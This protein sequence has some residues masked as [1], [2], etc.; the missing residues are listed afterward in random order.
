MISFQSINRDG[1]GVVETEGVPLFC[2]AK[3]RRD[4]LDQGRTRSKEDN[5]PGND[6]CDLCSRIC[7]G[8]LVHSLQTTIENYKSWPEYLHGAERNFRGVTYNCHRSAACCDGIGRCSRSCGCK[9]RRPSR[10]TSLSIVRSWIRIEPPGDALF[11]S[12]AGQQSL[13]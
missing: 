11:Q 1:Y 4:L 6:N 5:S 13:S 12:S 7:A 10:A 2:H 9:R 8:A 3:S